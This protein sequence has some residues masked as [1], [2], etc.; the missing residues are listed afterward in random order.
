MTVLVVL[1]AGLTVSV[2]YVIF[3]NG[4]V[5]NNDA[6]SIFFL[7]V[8]VSGIFALVSVF[9]G[10]GVLL[11]ACRA[12]TIDKPANNG[13]EE[14]L[15]NMVHDLCKQAGLK[16][17]PRVGYYPSDEYNAFAVESLGNLYIIFSVPMLNNFSREEIKAVAGHEVAHLVSGDSITKVGMFSGL[18]TIVYLVLFPLW[19]VLIIWGIVFQRTMGAAAFVLAGSIILFGLGKLLTFLGS[20]IANWYSRTREYEADRIG[21]KLAGKEAMISVLQKFRGSPAAKTGN[22]VLSSLRFNSIIELSEIFSTHPSLENRIKA[23]R[24]L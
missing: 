21:A 18:K 23:L 24:N 9:F 22:Q 14:W 17:M 6:G 15:V 7:A 19:V 8:V 16:R 10:A 13:Y 3:I 12:T 1:G 5:Y 2:L 20:M 11:R 4:G